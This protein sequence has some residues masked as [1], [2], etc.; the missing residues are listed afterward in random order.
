MLVLV[1]GCATA[2]DFLVG[3]VYN[4]LLAGVE[5]GGGVALPWANNVLHAALLLYG[6]LD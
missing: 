2:Y 3:V 1:R 4:L 5:G 6:V